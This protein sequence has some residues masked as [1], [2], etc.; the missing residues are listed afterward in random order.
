MNLAPSIAFDLPLPLKPAAGLQRWTERHLG[1]A[2]FFCRF[3]FGRRSNRPAQ[4][5]NLGHV[6]TS[7]R[8]R[9]FNIG[10]KVSP[11]ASAFA[12][13]VGGQAWLGV[14]PR[15]IYGKGVFF[16]PKSPRR[17][18]SRPN[19]SKRMTFFECLIFLHQHDQDTAKYI[20]VKRRV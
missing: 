2:G 19:L 12:C 6:Y 1:C 7:Y 4:P 17:F 5:I 11:D 13:R 10:C 20:K 15:Q 18:Q 3:K 8:G 9:R 14:E 16:S